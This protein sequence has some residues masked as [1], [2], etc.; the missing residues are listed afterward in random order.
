MF[1]SYDRTSESVVVGPA[2]FARRTGAPATLEFGGRVK[3]P[4]WWR[5]VGKYIRVRPRPYMQPAMRASQTKIAEFWKDS[6]H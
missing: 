3:A 1:F 5:G 4:S 6:V 2:A